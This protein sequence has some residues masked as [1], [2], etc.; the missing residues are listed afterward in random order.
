MILIRKVKEHHGWLGNMAPFPVEHDG[1]RWPTTE[2]LFQGLRFVD[3]EIRSKIRLHKS[4]MAAKMI[5]K[6]YKMQMVV[7]PMSA[8][9]LDNM[10]LC[11]KLK[12][13]QHPE[14]REKLIQT[15]E[16]PIMEDCT[17]RQR[18]SGLFW[19]AALIEGEWKGQNW[20]GRL[21]M[22]LRQQQGTNLLTVA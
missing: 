15:G 4:P 9:D 11:L 18:G 12:I 20:L 3:Q 19:G 8:L 14:L 7:E 21:W 6:K 13:E 1:Q 17:R 5:S 22:E 2:A 10:R 16:A